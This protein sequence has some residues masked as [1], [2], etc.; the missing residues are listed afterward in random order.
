MYLLRIEAATFI[1]RQRIYLFELR[2]ELLPCQAP[3]SLVL[4]PSHILEGIEGP[5]DCIDIEKVIKHRVR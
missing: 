3:F 2:H 4:L 1:Q 5:E